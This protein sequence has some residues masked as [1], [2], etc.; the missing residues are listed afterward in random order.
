MLRTTAVTV[1]G[2]LF[3]ALFLTGCTGLQPSGREVQQDPPEALDDQ[4]LAVELEGRN[5]NLEIADTAEEHLKGLSGR[6]ELA[7]DGG[8]LF[9]YSEARELVFW[10]DNTLLPLTLLYISDKGEILAIHDLYPND[11]TAVVSPGPVKYVI[12][13]KLGTLENSAGLIGHYL[14][15]P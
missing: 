2:I 1:A 11:R 7:D 13:V 15:L 9:I 4:I 14:Q 12:E 3:C 8:M 6:R 10:M 5:F